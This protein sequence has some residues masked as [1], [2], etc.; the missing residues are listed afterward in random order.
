MVVSGMLKR[1]QFQ[2]STE[3]FGNSPTVG[4]RW[5]QESL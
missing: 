5:N 2:S 4:N 3:I 1:N